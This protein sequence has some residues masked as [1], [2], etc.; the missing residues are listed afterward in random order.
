[1]LSTFEKRRPQVV[2]FILFVNFL[3][4]ATQTLT[5]VCRPKGHFSA[6]FKKLVTFNNS[7]RITELLFTMDFFKG[8]FNITNCTLRLPLWKMFMCK[9]ILCGYV[10]IFKFRSEDQSVRVKEHS[11]GEYVLSVA[12]SVVPDYCVAHVVTMNSKLKQSSSVSRDILS[13]ISVHLVPPPGDGG[14]EDLGGWPL[15]VQPPLQHH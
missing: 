3:I 12:V 15:P 11:G 10:K 9:Q 7:K 5:S 6:K 13:L 8:S 14:H 2:R 4:Q 1:M